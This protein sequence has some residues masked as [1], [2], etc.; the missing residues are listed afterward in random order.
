MIN[1][2]IT[3]LDI[4]G[5]QVAGKLEIRVVPKELVNKTNV[6]RPQTLSPVK[7]VQNGDAD[8]HDAEVCT[9]EAHDSPQKPKIERTKSILKQSSKEKEAGDIPSPKRENITFAAATGECQHSRKDNDEVD[10]EPAKE[11][12]S[13]DVDQEIQCDI[14]KNCIQKVASTGTEAVDGE[15]KTTDK[16][17]GWYIFVFSL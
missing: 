16:Q 5:F 7:L 14:R 10:K 6:P 2:L 1:L 8:H 15:S 17:I 3:Y 4:F 11:C 12:D 13:K 9:N